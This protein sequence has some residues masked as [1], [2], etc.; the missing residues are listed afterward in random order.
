MSRKLLISLSIASALAVTAGGSYLLLETPRAPSFETVK[1]NYQSSD[2]YLMDRKGEI[3]HQL[4]QNPKER[5]SLW[6]PSEQIPQVMVKALLKSEDKKF[7]KHEGVDLKALAASLYQRTF[8]KSERGGST[9][10]MQLVKLISPNKEIWQGYK[11][12][13]R[14]VKAAWQLEKSWSK[15]QIIE[16]YLNLVPFRGEHRGL[17]SITQS[18]YHKNSIGL[19]L[20]EATLLAVLI[21]SPNADQKQWLQRA[22][23]QERAWC[24]AMKSR[25]A[26]SNLRDIIL[27][28]PQGAYHISQRLSQ[29]GLRGQVQSTLSKDLQSYIQDTISS[30]MQSLS[31]QNVH[32]AAV[33]VIENKTGEV[34]AYVGGSREFST[35]PYVDG[36]R[37]LRQAGST[38]KPF[39][40]ATAFEK[41]ILNADSWLEDSAVDVVFDRGVYKPQNHDKQFYGWVQAKTALGSSLNVPA[42]K[43]FRL[44]NDDSFWGKLQA[45]HFR[46]LK[47]PDHYGP[48]L[49]LGVADV[50]LED[51]TQAYRALVNNGAYTSLKFV[52]SIEPALRNQVFTEKSASEVVTILSENQNRALGFGMDSA[53]SIPGTAVKTGTS[54]DMRDNWCVGMNSRF[55]VGVWVGNFNGQP[56]WNVM[57]VTGAAPI[58][59][60]TMEWLNERYPATESVPQLRTLAATAP[61]QAPQIKAPVQSQPMKYPKA[62]I[63]Y[64]QDGMV[65]AMDPAIPSLHQKM[66]L[67]VESAKNKNLRWK[68]DGKM[69]SADK[70]HLWQ[71]RPG[72]HSFELYDGQELNS[73][74]QILV[75]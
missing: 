5:S 45:L 27:Q 21:R 35:A 67:M 32:D 42:V 4:R 61:V 47:D 12:K 40:Y 29:T 19:T 2:L 14:Q 7:Y 44:L 11:G 6:L 23:W 26:T 70:T 51:L 66:P 69:I 3:L 31:A 63:I 9:I 8:K 10:S 71:P 1:K 75:K 58:W 64:P 52:K 72:K 53:L 13:L 24:D 30:Q 55:T 65:L 60:K 22:C 17:T 59:K 54:K 16:A 34:W 28:I 33:L 25:L 18:L 43:V 39:L 57:G 48:A 15:K 20:P 68:I 41:N 36:V 73:K 49:A 74:V 56:M 50:T 62:R 46:Q 37:A 38:L